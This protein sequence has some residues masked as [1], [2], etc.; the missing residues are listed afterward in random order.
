[1][2][3]QSA[4]Q[5][6]QEVGRVAVAQPVLGTYPGVPP[7]TSIACLPTL[8]PFL[9]F[10]RPKIGVPQ[11]S[12]LSSLVCIGPLIASPVANWISVHPWLTRFVRVL[13]R[14]LACCV[15]RRLGA[16]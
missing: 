5:R 12:T 4:L 11:I 8:V 9:V 15:V 10:S 1:M 7:E 16:G 6:V 13:P 14:Q 2:T 3:S